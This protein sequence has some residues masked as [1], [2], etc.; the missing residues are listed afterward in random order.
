MGEHHD[1]HFLMVED[2]RNIIVG[3]DLNDSVYSE[4][5]TWGVRLAIFVGFASFFMMEKTL[6]GLGSEGGGHSHSHSHSNSVEGSTSHSSGVEISH[7]NGEL[8]ARKEKKERKEEDVQ[9][10]ERSSQNG[11]SKLSAYLNLFGDFVHNMCVHHFSVLFLCRVA[12]SN[13]SALTASRKSGFPPRFDALHTIQI[14]PH[15]LK[16]GCFLLLQPSDRS[17]DHARLLRTRDSPR[18]RGLLHLDS[19]RLHQE[20]GYA[21]SVHNRYWRLCES[22]WN[23]VTF[24]RTHAHQSSFP[25]SVGLN[26]RS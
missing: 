24:I 9:E 26:Q 16:H 10:E 14:D 4:S 2:K 19:Q 18:D 5:L 22:D 13:V 23:A 3:Y 25:S 15:S 17:Y 1:V 20:T 21:I 12:H 7:G 11:P 6:R 8:K